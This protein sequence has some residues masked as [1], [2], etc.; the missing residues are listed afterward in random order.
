[1]KMTSAD[2][3]LLNLSIT[4][5]IRLRSG[6]WVDC[7]TSD[8]VLKAASQDILDMLPTMSCANASGKAN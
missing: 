1:M 5:Y 8:C 4:R 2:P 6:A 7:T 3:T